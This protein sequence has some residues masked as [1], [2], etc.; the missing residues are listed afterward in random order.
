MM[1]FGERMSELFLHGELIADVL[2]DGT[3]GVLL[4]GALSVINLFLT[5]QRELQRTRR[6]TAYAD[7]IRLRDLAKSKSEQSIGVV[8]LQYI[9][10]RIT[11]LASMLDIEHAAATGA[12]AANRTTRRSRW[13]TIFSM[14]PAVALALAGFLIIVGNGFSIGIVVT[15]FA[16]L[17]AT[18]YLGHWTSRVL[19]NLLIRRISQIFISLTICFISFFAIAVFIS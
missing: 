17:V 14:A 16:S 15:C 12:A 4:G 7:L 10:D 3:K 11:H 13:D 9:E 8:P 18:Y 1:D 2:K 5:D 6:V 19:D